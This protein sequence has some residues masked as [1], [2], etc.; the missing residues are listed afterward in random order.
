M[1]RNFGNC[2]R[3][4][5]IGCK[6]GPYIGHGRLKAARQA[7]HQMGQDDGC[8]TFGGRIDRDEGGV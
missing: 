7:L 4:F 1:T 3:A 5:S 2:D 6:F 8:D